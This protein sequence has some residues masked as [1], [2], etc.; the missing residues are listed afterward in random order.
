MDNERKG[1]GQRGVIVMIDRSP[2]TVADGFADDP[3]DRGV[4]AREAIQFLGDS[5]DSRGERWDG[6]P[7]RMRRCRPFS[8]RSAP[9]RRSI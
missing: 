5:S 8:V 3:G 1:V 2:Y 6:G 9:T 4:R 7:H